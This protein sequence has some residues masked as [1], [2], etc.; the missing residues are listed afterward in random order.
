MTKRKSY[1]PFKLWGSYVGLVLSLVI[2][3]VMWRIAISGGESFSG[4]I[5]ST[6]CFVPFSC[7]AP[8]GLAYGS[9][10][11]GLI[12][13]GIIGFLLGY[14]IHALIRRFRR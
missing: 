1:N 8:F 13:F 3:F 7:S 10:T 4:Q 5:F 9:L 6:L 11:Y 14:G 2:G 12:I